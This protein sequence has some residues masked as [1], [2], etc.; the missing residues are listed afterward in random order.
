MA[1]RTLLAGEKITAAD[2]KEYTLSTNATVSDGVEQRMGTDGRPAFYNE[3]GE[4][5]NEDGSPL[6][7]SLSERKSAK[8]K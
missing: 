6:R 3:A 1:T 2:G 8:R 7:G 4:E 5:V